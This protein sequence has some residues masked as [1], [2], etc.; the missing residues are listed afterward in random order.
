MSSNIC[1]WKKTTSGWF[2]E[3]KEWNG[4]NK[5][6]LLSEYTSNNKC[7]LNYHTTYE[8]M[9]PHYLLHNVIWLGLLWKIVQR[10]MAKI[11]W[12]S[13]PSTELWKLHDHE[14]LW[15]LV[16][17]WQSLCFYTS[18]VFSLGFLLYV[19]AF[20]CMWILVCVW[21]CGY[22]WWMCVWGSVATSSGVIWL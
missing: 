21:K 20:A 17:F 6:H 7:I 3:N 13:S 8:E 15:P 5:P 2:I 10:D 4:F 1:V 12:N 19:H 16:C 9:W 18:C 14:F 22:S 11:A